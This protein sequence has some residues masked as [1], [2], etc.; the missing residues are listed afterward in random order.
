MMSFYPGQKDNTPVPRK[1]FIGRGNIYDRNGNPLAQNIEVE[2]VYVNPA[3]VYDPE[4]VAE[5]L[6][7]T[8]GMDQ[9]QLLTKISAKK[10][11]VWI[12]RKCNIRE[13]ETLKQFDLSG[14]GFVSEQKR[15]YPKRELASTVIGFVGL[16][17]QGLSGVEHF[18]QDK[19][20]GKTIRRVMEKERA[21]KTLFGP[22]SIA[23][24]AMR[25]AWTS[26]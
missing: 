6:S 13:V 11:F 10:H 24:E 25:K 5:V 1:Y 19:L 16:D 21:G 12:K 14:I 20:K 22:L 18:H 4:R 17:N 26:C 7:S 23:P 15:F 2:S 8:L 9:A 3:E